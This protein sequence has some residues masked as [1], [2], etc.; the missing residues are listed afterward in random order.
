M[1]GV[2]TCAL[3]IYGYSVLLNQIPLLSSKFE[4][5]QNT[6]M[7][8]I[9]RYGSLIEDLLEMIQAN[10]MLAEPISRESEVL[11]AEILYAVTHEGARSVS[12]VLTRRTRLSFEL[13]DHGLAIAR[14]V[15]ELIAP[16]LRWDEDKI[17]A[18]IADYEKIV[19]REISELETN[20]KVAIN[21]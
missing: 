20:L 14:I 6:L 11:K 4:L 5:S 3:P 18:S 21:S 19:N 8:L 10:R 12:D 13:K 9:N 15:A 2:Q 16:T 17:Q 1:T 7:H